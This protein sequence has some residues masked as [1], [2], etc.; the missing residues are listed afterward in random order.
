MARQ[1]DL[2]VIG[3]GT[4]AMVA[5]SASR[6]QTAAFAS[7]RWRTEQRSASMPTSSFMQLDEL[8]R[9]TP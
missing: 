5:Y 2:V 4:A 1:Y 9:S 7:R 3:A 6:R 8:P